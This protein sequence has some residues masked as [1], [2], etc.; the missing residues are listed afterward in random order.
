MLER[1]KQLV[2]IIDAVNIEKCDE[3]EKVTKKMKRMTEDC[4]RRTLFTTFYDTTVSH[5]RVCTYDTKNISFIMTQ[6]QNPK[7]TRQNTK[8]QIN[9]NNQNNNNVQPSKSTKPYIIYQETK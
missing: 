2:L 3:E 8:K 1:Y 9:K 4:K 6:N 5:R 7:I